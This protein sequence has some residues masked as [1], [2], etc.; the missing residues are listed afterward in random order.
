M[1]NLFFI[2]VLTICFCFWCC[3]NEESLIGNNLLNSGEHI[4]ENHI[5]N[6]NITT[7]IELDDSVSASG[8]KSLLGSYVDPIF[9]QVDASFC[10]QI[11][12]PVNEYNPHLLI[13]YEVK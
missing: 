5:H 7:Q 3:E 4:L 8:Q 11:Q 6:F 2:N 12:I 10:F 1:R 9:G 13:V